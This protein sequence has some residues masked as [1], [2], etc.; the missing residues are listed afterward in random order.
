MAVMDQRNGAV[1]EEWEINGIHR[2]I[3]LLDL[4]IER[5]CGRERE[6][7]WDQEEGI[8][9]PGGII[10]T[11]RRVRGRISS[12]SIPRLVVEEEE[13]IHTR[14]DP[15]SVTII[16]TINMDTITDLLSSNTIREDHHSSNNNSKVHLLTNSSKRRG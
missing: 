11:V 15:I 10:R 2:S 4:R 3:P 14:A 13:T 8:T 9:R 6:R 5:K 12:S 7:R 16:R 1:E